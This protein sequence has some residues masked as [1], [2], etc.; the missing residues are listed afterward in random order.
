VRRR[1]GASPLHLVAHLAALAAAGWALLQIVRT[2]DAAA[3]VLV[4]LGAAVVLHDLVLLPA[5]SGLDR[6]AARASGPAINH[7]RVPAALSLLLLLVF[8]PVISGRGSRA[9]ERAGGAPFE[10]YLGRWLLVTAGFF[11]VS[12]ALYAV[13]RPRRPRP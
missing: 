3:E 11:A 13:R 6:V 10:G 4:W 7:V 9:F 12:A 2:L 8:L 1:Y 5:Y